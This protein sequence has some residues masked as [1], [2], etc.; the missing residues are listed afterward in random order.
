MIRL[1]VPSDTQAIGDLIHAAY[2]HYI[3][4]IGKPPGPMTD[5]YAAR[6]GDGQVWV[7]EQ[8]TGTIAGVLVLEDV[9]DGALLL[10]NIA[11]APAAQG[12]GIGRALMLFAED[13]A[14]RRGHCRIRLYTHV[15]MVEIGRAHV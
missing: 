14:R 12:T 7:A 6:V 13:E 4:R 1:A 9:P 10:D 15:R 2:R 3:S 11:V 5:D 8:P